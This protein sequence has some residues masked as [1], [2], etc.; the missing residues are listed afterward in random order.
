M[1]SRETNHSLA[2]D[3]HFS[4]D[5]AMTVRS[6]LLR[7]DAASA[8]EG[9]RTQ[10][11]RRHKTQ[12]VRFKDLADGP[13]EDGG[14]GTPDAA[15]QGSEVTSQQASLAGCQGLVTNWYPAR[16]CSLTL[17]TPRRACMST[18]IQT[19][20][21]LQKQF[22][23]F[24]IRSKSIGDLSEVDRQ[25]GTDPEPGGVVAADEPKEGAEESKE[26]R[27]E[28]GVEEKEEESPNGRV[29][30]TA[31]ESP[32]T[33]EDP[34]LALPC[35]QER[36]KVMEEAQGS[37]SNPL[38]VCHRLKDKINSKAI[39]G[40]FTDGELKAFP[41]GQHCVSKGMKSLSIKPCLFTSEASMPLSKE[42]IVEGCLL[43]QNACHKLK[44]SQHNLDSNHSEFQT[45]GSNPNNPN[46]SVP[47]EHVS[48]LPKPCLKTLFN[49]KPPSGSHRT[50]QSQLCIP[51]GNPCEPIQVKSE[52]LLESPVPWGGPADPSSPSGPSLHTGN[53]LQLLQSGS[54]PHANGMESARAV[55]N[56]GANS[57]RNTRCEI[58]SL[59]SRLQNMENVLQTS[60]QTIKVLLDVIQDL[61]KKEAIRDGRQSYHTGQDIA[62]CGTCRDCACIIYRT[63]RICVI[64]ISKAKKRECVG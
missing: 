23:A 15:A 46:H 37:N 4:S 40:T 43:K 22:P 45:P 11:R 31:T 7:R 39:T 57:G 55:E 41:A 21:S 59:Q 36:E 53:R 28:K 54:N 2:S 16:P 35:F 10:H 27:M 18:A 17:P 29:E 24:R 30:K 5:R 25:E 47:K 3:A 6:V 12:Q 20:P 44:A 26:K 19:S 42:N 13:E 64:L 1:V 60:Q 49:P 14:K 32:A 48:S 52:P 62:N 63:V 56:Q 33:S 8:A 51:A 61:E 38:S 50:D 34:C 58:T 9:K